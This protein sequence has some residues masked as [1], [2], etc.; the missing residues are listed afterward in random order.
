MLRFAK[1][2]CLLDKSTTINSS[3]KSKFGKSNDTKQSIFIARVLYTNKRHLLYVIKIF[4]EVHVS[5]TVYTNQR[6]VVNSF[7]KMMER[8]RESC[9]ISQKKIHL[10]YKEN[11]KNHSFNHIF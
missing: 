11:K 5:E 8:V 1:A 7:P 2:T 9:A 6:Q 4:E 3:N 10:S